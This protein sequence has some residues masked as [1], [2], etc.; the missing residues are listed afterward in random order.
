[1]W[2]EP[3]ESK[4]VL[5][6][7]K[8]GQNGCKISPGSPFS[9]MSCDFISRWNQGTKKERSLPFCLGYDR[10]HNSLFVTVIFSNSKRLYIN[11]LRNWCH[12]LKIALKFAISHNRLQ[13]TLEKTCCQCIIKCVNITYP[14]SH[15]VDFGINVLHSG[16]F[17]APCGVKGL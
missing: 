1:M 17:V 8:Q 5:L 16:E 3:H 10:S 14:Y 9:V 11:T 7:A 6:T 4:R 15:W 12:F 2:L 13:R